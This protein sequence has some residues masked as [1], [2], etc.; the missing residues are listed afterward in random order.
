MWC[1]TVLYSSAES[2][3]ASSRLFNP[4]SKHCTISSTQHVASH[5][6]KYFLFSLDS[7][8]KCVFRSIQILVAFPLHLSF[9]RLWPSR[10]DASSPRWKYLVVVYVSSIPI[11]V[12]VSSCAEAAGWQH[13]YR[14]V[15]R[16][17]QAE[18]LAGCSRKQ[19]CTSSAGQ[20]VST[21]FLQVTVLLSAR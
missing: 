11:A 19:Y 13:R 10:H 1:H 2:A 9:A 3:G 8:M 6:H 15:D 5:A 18:S 4:P 17:R 12:T 14:C 16:I 7:C 21:Q 20:K